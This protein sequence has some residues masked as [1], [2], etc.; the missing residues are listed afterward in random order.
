MSGG[1]PWTDA[2]D[3]ILRKHYRTR[4]GRLMARALL[5]HRSRNALASRATKL[6]LK[7]PGTRWTRA[8][9]KLLLR[10]WADV[11][12]RTLKEFFPGRTWPAI[13]ARADALGLPPP[14]Q[15]LQPLQAVATAL[16]YDAKTLRKIL[17]RRGV[18]I[19]HYAAG[20]R[21]LA[22]RAMPRYRVDPVLAREAV[23][24]ELAER[25]A[26]GR[27]TLSEAAARTG[28]SR[29]ALRERLA[30]L[31]ALPESGA[32]HCALVDPALVDR[33]ARLPRRG[34]APPGGLAA[35][36]RA[37]GVSVHAAARLM[38]ARGWHVG[39]GRRAP[40]ALIAQVLG[41]LTAGTLGARCAA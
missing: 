28:F 30:L 40:A 6:G 29:T 9:D 31:G 21:A 37:A 1:A 24:A 41:E 16:G 10:E 7:R 5:S 25:A 15:E 39:K 14:Q 17:E 33:A 11:T 27:E 32:G 13:C 34:G 8:E 36:C 3:A 22:G 4:R 26:D 35:A 19:E 12:P 23:E 20:E 18:E 38:R 2:E